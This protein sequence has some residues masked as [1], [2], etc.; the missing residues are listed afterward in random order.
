M[1]YGNHGIRIGIT[2]L[3]HVEQGFVSKI[4]LNKFDKVLI[5]EDNIPRLKWP[6]GVTVDIFL[7]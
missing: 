4:K 1:N 3:L 2:N 6:L 5:K 7:L